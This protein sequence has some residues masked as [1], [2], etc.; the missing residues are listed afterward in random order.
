[1]CEDIMF[2]RES[3]PGISFIHSIFP[4]LLFLTLYCFCTANEC[5]CLMAFDLGFVEAFCVFT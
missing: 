3:S 1:M 2:S 5:V 4:L